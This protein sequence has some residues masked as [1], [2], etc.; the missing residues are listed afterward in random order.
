MLISY[1]F[2]YNDSSLLTK[3][4]IGKRR[5]EQNFSC[6]PIL[7]LSVCLAKF[8]YNMMKF[9]FKMTLFGSVSYF[10]MMVTVWKVVGNITLKV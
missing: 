4:Y 2:I 9:L 7:F 10:A 1:L 6:V 8:K 5:D 3:V